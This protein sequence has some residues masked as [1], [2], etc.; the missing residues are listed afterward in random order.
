MRLRF[1]VDKASR[2]TLTLRRRGV[3]AL[4][5]SASVS[6]GTHWFAVTPRRRGPL[7]VELRA[8]DLAGNASTATAALAVVRAE[9][10]KRG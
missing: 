4:Q 5:V 7:D 8:V 9:G 1:R 10:R 3:V 6:R 2:V